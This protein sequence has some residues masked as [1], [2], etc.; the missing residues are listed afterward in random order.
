MTFGSVKNVHQPLVRASRCGRSE[1]TASPKVG[2]VHST[3]STTAA[4]EAPGR[5]SRSLAWPAAGAGRTG[6]IGGVLVIGRT[7]VCRGAHRAASAARSC[8]T[9]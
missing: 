9:L 8:R 5:E 7:G 2:S 6:A 3:A 1:V 4:I